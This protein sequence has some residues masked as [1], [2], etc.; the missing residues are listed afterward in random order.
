MSNCNLIGKFTARACIHF[1]GGSQGLWQFPVSRLSLQMC[2]KGKIR[3]VGY[4]AVVVD[5]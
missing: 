3:I 4:S 5:T 2:K 1:S